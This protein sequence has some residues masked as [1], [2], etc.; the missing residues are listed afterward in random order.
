[1][2]GITGIQGITGTTGNTGAT[3][4]QGIQGIQGIQGL[5]GPIGASGVTGASGSIGPVGAQGSQGQNGA[6]GPTGATGSVGAIGFSGIVGA[7][8]ATGLPS[9]GGYF[10]STATSAIAANALIPINSGSTIFGSGISLTSATTVTLSTPGIYLVSYYFQGSPT[11]GNE[12]ISVRLILNG[13]QVVG[14]F[15]FYVTKNNFVLEPAIS[16]TMVIEVTSPNSTLSL[17]NGP[18]DIGYVT[19]L[20]GVTTASLNIL[21]LI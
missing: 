5:Q 2:Q 15:I 6:V 18:L 17:Q 9:G 10:F 3:G 21:K 12:T 16:N 4:P 13:T 19:V 14:S 20:S 1:M 11:G 7:T 8:G